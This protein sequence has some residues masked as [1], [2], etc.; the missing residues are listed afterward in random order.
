[1]SFKRGVKKVDR[2]DLHRVWKKLPHTMKTFD[3]YLT[4][5]DGMPNG[6]RQY[7]RDLDAWLAREFGSDPRRPD[8]VAVMA[9]GGLTADGWYREML[10]R[11][12]GRRLALVDDH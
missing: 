10:R 2:Y 12:G 9:V 1:M 6:L 5:P 11:D 3:L 8:P 7:W 4:A